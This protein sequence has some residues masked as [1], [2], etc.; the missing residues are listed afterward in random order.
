MHI[1]TRTRATHKYNIC[2]YE[3]TE[4]RKTNEADGYFSSIVRLPFCEGRPCPSVISVK[5]PFFSLLLLLEWIYLALVMRAHLF[6]I[7]WM[8]EAG[9]RRVYSK[10]T[11]IDLRVID[12]RV[13]ADASICVE[14]LSPGEKKK[15]KANRWNMIAFFSLSRNACVGQ[16]AVE[17]LM[18]C[19]NKHWFFAHIH[20]DVD[21]RCRYTCHRLMNLWNVSAWPKT[22][23]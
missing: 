5:A 18:V 15:S 23:L 16:T 19:I 21:G 2:G 17:P 20:T 8:D 14:H 4:M 10:H 9:G 3:N 22:Y 7:L 1:Y 6:G 13:Y 12:E 11:P